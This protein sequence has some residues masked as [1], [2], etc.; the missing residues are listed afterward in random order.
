[1]LFNAQDGVDLRY[2]RY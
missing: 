2:D 1:M